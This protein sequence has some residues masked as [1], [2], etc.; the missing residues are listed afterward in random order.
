MDYYL[1]DIGFTLGDQ[2]ELLKV[3]AEKFR[4]TG[5]F[6]FI[7]EMLMLVDDIESPDLLTYLDFLPIGGVA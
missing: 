5:D 7:S 1:D 4:D 6:V 3:L 2:I